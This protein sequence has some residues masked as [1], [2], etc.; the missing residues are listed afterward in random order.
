M[1]GEKLSVKE[2]IGYGLGDTASNIVFQVIVNYMVIFYTDV[3]GITAAAAG[4]LMLVVRLFDMVTDPLM[5][6]IADRTNTRWGKYRPYLILT[7]IPYG[8]LAVV[9]FSTPDF[10]EGGKLIY[11]YITYALLMTA[12]TAVNIPY[13]ALGGVITGDAK[14]RGE[15]QAYRFAMAMVG[16]FIVTSSM[17]WLVSTFG[18]GDDTKGYQYAMG[19]L[20]LIACVC[21][22][23]CFLT[24]RERV[25]PTEIRDENNLGE[26]FVA[27]WKDLFTL[28]RTNSQWGI[29]ALVAIFLLLL[30]I[31]R[32]GVTLFYTKY[33]LACD[34]PSLGVAIPFWGSIEEFCNP[35]T[36][37]T[38]F[39]TLGFVA[40]SLG[41]VT[42]I[43]LTK[44]FCKVSI[45]RFA[46]VMI[47]IFSTL[48]FF[49]PP[50]MV[51]ASLVTFML[52]QYF[53]I[54]LVSNMF[55]MVADTVDYGEYKTGKR[56][57]AMTFSAHLFALKLGVALGGA[58]VGWLLAYFDYAAP[59]DG[60]DQVQ[61]DRSLFGILVIFSLV[62]SLC[63]LIVFILGRFYSLDDKRLSEIHAVIKSR[64][65]NEDTPPVIN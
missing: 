57:T 41:A 63:A 58:M 21:F 42:T 37:G 52:T 7:S 50:E 31:M 49:I 24:T 9:A 39:L 34:M 26:T 30:V 53:Q 2:K 29:M 33:F 51:A 23:L 11:A 25:P 35:D 65:E 19:V 44:K 4:T 54:M 27:I 47:V 56:V 6:G 60:V 28:V 64:E 13:S 46:A 8:I 16:G 40:A 10:D 38:T 15:V 62:P 48:L 14:E 32:G 17:L 20:S 18:N 59:I 5:G 3:F 1:S 43:F 22:V 55:A 45:F 36:L 61:S 12:Y